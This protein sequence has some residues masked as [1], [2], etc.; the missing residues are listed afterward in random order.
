MPQRCPVCGSAVVRDEGEAA[1]RCTAGLFCPAQRKQALLHFASRRAMDIE[2]LGEKLVDQLVDDGLVRTPADLYALDAARLAGLERMGEKSAA[3]L[4]PRSSAAS[5]RHWPA[6]S[7]RSASATW[8]RRRRAILRCISAASNA[9]MGADERR[10]AA[11]RGRRPGGRREHRAFFAEPHN[12]KAVEE[13]L[14]AGIEIAEP[15]TA[16]RGAGKRGSGNSRQ[17]LRPDRHAAHADPGRGEG[18]DRG[19]RRTVT[20]SVSKK[21]DY[22]VA[23]ADPGS[24]YDKAREL[25]VTVID[26]AGLLKLLKEHR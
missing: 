1:T 3:N 6:S 23:G 18:E 11:G 7:T 24:K 5:T 4:S 17:A 9:L 26:E 21:T 14:A 10:L 16:R 22:V 20:G 2:G 15:A 8:A 12:R 19:A 13:L 25:G